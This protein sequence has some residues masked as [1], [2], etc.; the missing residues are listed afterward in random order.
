MKNILKTLIIGSTVATVFSAC[1][2]VDPLPFYEPGT[3]PVLSASAATA[4]PTVGDSAGIATKLTWTNPNY[5]GWDAATNLYVIQVDSAGKNFSNPKTFKTLNGVLT[6]DVLNKDLNKFVLDVLGYAATVPQDLEFRLISTTSN[7]NEQYISN[8]VA[9]KYTPYIPAIPDVE[10]HPVTTPPNNELFMVGG[11]TPGGWNNP[12]P[13]PSQKL[14]RVSNTL[15]TI[16]LD[17]NGG[18]SYLLLTENGSWNS[19]YAIPDRNIADVEKRGYFIYNSG[20]DFKGPA[21]SGRYIMRFDFAQ[22]YYDI[23]RIG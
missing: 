9:L 3:A 13:V 7:N 18:E 8:K 20:Q 21:K 4:T 2:K 15:Y 11:A 22:G 17:L 1:D 16:T 6:N 10:D 5:S 23:V 14:T 19:K 12:V